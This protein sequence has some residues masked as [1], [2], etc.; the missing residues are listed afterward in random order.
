MPSSG[1]WFS[2]R[3]WADV[4]VTLTPPAASDQKGETSVFCFVTLQLA[5]FHLVDK[6]YIIKAPQVIPTLP[7]LG[8][9]LWT[10][11][12]RGYW[13]L[14]LKLELKGGKRCFL[15]GCSW[16]QLDAPSKKCP[17]VNEAGDVKQS[18]KIKF[19]PK[20]YHQSFQ[21]SL[22]TFNITSLLPTQAF[23]FFHHR[24]CS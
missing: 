8:S 10:G 18:L 14:W 21:L 19:H 22:H 11:A 5:Q 9:M 20:T 16:T 23:I 2:S 3:Q 1:L 6:S 4:R 7:S 13:W 24:I 12:L 15:C 17:H